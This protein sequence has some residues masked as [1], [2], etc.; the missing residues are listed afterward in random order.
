MLLVGEQSFV[1]DVEVGVLVLLGTG[2]Y[3]GI[4]CRDA[5]YQV[6]SDLRWCINCAC[7]VGRCINCSD[8]GNYRS[9]QFFAVLFY[10]SW[11]RLIVIVF[12][13]GTD[14]RR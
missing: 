10:S 9:W 4:S 1:V 12:N 7:D 13:G 11:E 3:Y 5:C 6:G 14:V 8:I 2:S